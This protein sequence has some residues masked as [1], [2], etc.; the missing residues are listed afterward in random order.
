MVE[1]PQRE[2]WTDEP[3]GPEGESPPTVEPYDPSQVR[4]RLR[5]A[6]AGGLLAL[7]A[8]IIIGSF[9]SLWFD[10]ANSDEIDR[11]LTMVL[12]P[13]IALVGAA[14]GFYYGGRVG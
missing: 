6:L 4:E 2:D 9:I 3:T 8:F 10:W 12:A 13:V 14:T 1:E 5:G 11:I 7:L